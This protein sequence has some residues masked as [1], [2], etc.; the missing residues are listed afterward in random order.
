[1]ADG[2]I[3]YIRLMLDQQALKQ[4]EK[5]AAEGAKRSAEA[6][7]NELQNAG[8]VGRAAQTFTSKLREAFEADIVK[9]RKELAQGLVDLP[10][11]QRRA[12][13][14]AD[15]FNQEL[16]KGLK[17]IKGLDAAT[18]SRLLGVSKV[19]IDKVAV[20]IHRSFAREA[21]AG[22]KEGLEAAAQRAQGF[23]SLVERG[24]PKTFTK[25][26]ERDAL[27][28]AK[29][30]RIVYNQLLE[31]TQLL[32]QLEGTRLTTL[33]K[34]F[35]WFGISVNNASSTVKGMVAQL[36]QLGATQAQINRALPVAANLF[37]QT[38]GTVMQMARSLGIVYTWYQAFNF[39]KKAINANADLEKSWARLSVT[40]SD[41]GHTLSEV[42]P[43][44]EALIQ[45]NIRLGYTQGQTLETLARLIQITGDQKESVRALSTVLDI[46]A[47]GYMTLEQATRLTGR[48]MIGDVGQFQRYGVFLEK[49]IDAIA[50]LSARFGGET[51][52]RAKTF[53][54]ELE[55]MNAQLDLMKTNLGAVIAE[56][57]K[58]NGFFGTMSDTID[59]VSDMIT[60]NREAISVW[61]QLF[62]Y[63]FLGAVVVV[64]SLTA[65]FLTLIKIV[66]LAGVIMG[67]TI[68]A[69]PALTQIAF[70]GMVEMAAKAFGFIQG[71]MDKVFG[72]NLKKGL[73]DIADKFK[74]MREEGQ[75]ALAANAKEVKLAAAEV[76]E[77]S[78]IAR[79]IP[80][81][82]PSHARHPRAR[83]FQNITNEVLQL[84]RVALGDDLQKSQAA[85]ERLNEIREELVKNA[86]EEKDNERQVLE[87]NS[88]IAVIDKIREDLKKK[89]LR[90][91]KDQQ[92]EAEIT[93]R[94]NLLGNIAL[95]EDL[96][97]RAMALADLSKL[98]DELIAKRDKLSIRSEKYWVTQ[99][100]IKEIED[101]IAAVMDQEDSKF[102]ARVKRLAEFVDLNID[103]ENSVKELNTLYAEQQKLLD[104]QT[105]SHDAHA[106]ARANQIQ[107]EQAL[108]REID[109]TS[110]RI[111]DLGEDIKDPEKRANAERDL[112]K[113]RNQLN[114]KLARGLV[115]STNIKQVQQQI[116]DIDQIIN[117]QGTVNLKNLDR[118]ITAAER[119]LKH[120]STRRAGLTALRKI[121][122][123]IT[124]ELERQN[125]TAAERLRLIEKQK[126]VAEDIRK[127]DEPDA[128]VIDELKRIFKDDL[129]SIAANAA[130]EMAGHFTDAFELI[131][132]DSRILRRG[133][134]ALPRGLGLALANELRDVAKSKVKENLAWAV[135][136]TALGIGKLATGNVPAAGEHFASAGEHFAAAAAWGLLAGGAAGLARSAGT[137]LNNTMGTNGDRGAG[138]DQNAGRGDIYLYIDGVDPNNP[139]HQQ[140]VGDTQREY[141]ERY[142]GR[143]VVMPAGGRP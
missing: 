117:E 137:A 138:N 18:R 42:R 118:T 34:V 130:D 61:F 103:L 90:L 12:K 132:Q 56:G 5:D 65:V 59:M 54:G 75:K 62:K 36:Q 40:V 48:A 23:F 121:E 33:G 97:N 72:T 135:E 1:M 113:I 10:E 44:V 100:H 142:G 46:A 6:V 7:T 114:D 128:N 53:R 95:G 37:K 3:Q 104:D 107:I 101:R 111:K 39:F 2:I 43:G 70:A 13:L 112:L 57:L 129:P 67:G 45:K 88:R 96:K 20:E 35:N 31:R 17:G 24:A 78:P 136:Q 68:R 32:Y 21:A 25:A 81:Q 98:H 51:A 108:R 77:G 19:D 4:L 15:T 94:I 69:L 123:Q 55:I 85:M 116:K 30:N 91:E 134:E 8:S 26:E 14:L 76:S 92:H 106:K 109:I 141:T 11:A 126:R 58:A 80:E 110:E 102:N 50:Q 79:E 47:S 41:F 115:V 38:A 63:A 73:D 119:L 52:A 86:E 60:E 71:L 28:A 83:Y 99:N 82:D 66:Q 131:L 87:Y 127:A 9:I 27:K 124:A 89:Q 139:R 29:G 93:R 16:E 122:E 140:L 64:A 120:G 49:N 133:L 105:L 125:L 84:R 22:V 143:I 74:K